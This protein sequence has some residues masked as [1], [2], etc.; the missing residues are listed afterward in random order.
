ML[1]L[2]NIIALVLVLWAMILLVIVAKKIGGH[3]GKVFK[4]LVLGIFF[5]IFI[6]AIIE[7]LGYLG[8][9]DEK[10]LL[11][12]MGVLLSLGGIFFISAGIFAGKKLKI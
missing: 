5:S 10:Q 6:H 2:S 12:I 4:L 8:F 9:I 3:V 11:F 1:I 7:L